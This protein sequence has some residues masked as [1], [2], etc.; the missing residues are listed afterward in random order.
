MTTL[1][2]QKARKPLV[3]RGKYGKIW[4]YGEIALSR[5]L[6]TF[7]AFFSLL[8]LSVQSPNPILRRVFVCFV[9]W[10]SDA[11]WRVVIPWDWLRIGIK[12]YLMVEVVSIVITLFLPSRWFCCDSRQFFVVCPS[13]CRAMWILTHPHAKFHVNGECWWNSDVAND[14][15]FW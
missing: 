10:W 13:C 2:I 6:T 15:G 8:H 1:S 7:I 11:N 5:T 12:W 3:G 14:H 9:C 4:S